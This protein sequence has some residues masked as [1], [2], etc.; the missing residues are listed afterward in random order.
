[1]SETT[2]DPEAWLDDDGQPIRCWCGEVLDDDSFG[3][4]GGECGGT[5]SINC[6]CGG[7]FCV[8]HHHGAYE[9]DGCAECEYEADD[10]P[11]DDDDAS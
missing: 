3:Q 2:R 5:R 1:M 11:E 10:Y 8:C 4:S 6:Y 7:D 9:C